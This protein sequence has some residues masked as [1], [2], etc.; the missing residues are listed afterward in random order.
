MKLKKKLS[1]KK[2]KNPKL[3]K[4]QRLRHF[5]GTQVVSIKRQ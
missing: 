1:K 2:K 4:Q 5:Q 3:Y